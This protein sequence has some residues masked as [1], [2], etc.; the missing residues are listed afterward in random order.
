[1]I[2]ILAIIVVLLL[3]TIAGVYY[4]YYRP[5]S[6]QGE[7]NNLLLDTPVAKT[8]PRICKFDALAYAALYPDLAKAFGQDV[9]QLKNHYINMGMNEN[10]SPCGIQGCNFDENYYANNNPDLLSAF[11]H[12]KEKLR[13]HYR[14]YG[15]NENRAV[16]ACV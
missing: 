10:R 14:Y 4:Y 8:E 11:G 12:D 7:P 5:M 2:L 3:I 6:H 1:M 15:I 13:Q 9:T 16:S